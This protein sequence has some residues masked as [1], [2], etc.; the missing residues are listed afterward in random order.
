MTNTEAQKK[1]VFV[2][3]PPKD[4]LDKGYVLGSTLRVI[5]S[6]AQYL[7]SDELVRYVLITPPDSCTLNSDLEFV[8]VLETLFINLIQHGYLAYVLKEK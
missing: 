7:D 6:H 2:K 8:C 4:F 5:Q 1:L 3:T